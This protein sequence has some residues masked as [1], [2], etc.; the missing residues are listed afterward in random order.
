MQADGLDAEARVG[1]P[2]DHRGI[3]CDRHVFRI[4]QHWLKA[5]EP[6]PFYNPVNDYVIL[7]TA[8]EIEQHHEE[9]V[10][11]TSLKEEWEII[12]S[13]NDGSHCK[14][15]DLP[16]MMESL[17]VSFQGKEQHLEEAQAT[18]VVHPQHEGR[19]HVVVRAVSVTMG[20]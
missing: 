14:S 20:A 2:S 19:Q 13:A 11:V 3:V 18:V 15:A 10:Q 17:S 1:V 16:A 7:P 12:S 5:G 9:T 4:L 6:D 8:F